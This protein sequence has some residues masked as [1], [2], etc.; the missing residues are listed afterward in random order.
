MKLTLATIV[1]SATAN[2]TANYG[3]EEVVMRTQ[4]FI[5]GS[6]ACGPFL[7]SQR[8]DADTSSHAAYP[9]AP[10][11]SR[12]TD[13]LKLGPFLML[14]LLCR[15]KAKRPLPNRQESTLPRGCVLAVR[16]SSR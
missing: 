16:Y 12:S 5:A 14:V 6:A 15:R 9:I 7:A 13:A 11:R 1:G 2:A 10:N 3:Q 4:E 8:G